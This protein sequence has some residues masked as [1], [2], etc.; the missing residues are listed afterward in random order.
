MSVEAVTILQAITAKF[1]QA[2]SLIQNMIDA[3][4]DENLYI[5]ASL[6]LQL[7]RTDIEKSMRLLANEERISHQPVPFVPLLNAQL[8]LD[9]C[10]ENLRNNVTTEKRE[11][12]FI[13]LKSD[14]DV[15]KKIISQFSKNVPKDEY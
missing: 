10:L 2:I 4:E 12:D 14:V 1:I 9:T 13:T 7:T 5:S 11:D 6:R 8:S 15:M 3:P